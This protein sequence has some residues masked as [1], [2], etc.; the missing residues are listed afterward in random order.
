MRMYSAVLKLSH[1]DGQT[2]VVKVIRGLLQ[3]L[4]A[5]AL[6]KCVVTQ[7]AEHDVSVLWGQR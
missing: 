1:A 4:V 7:P 3:V 2:D 5:N 6:K